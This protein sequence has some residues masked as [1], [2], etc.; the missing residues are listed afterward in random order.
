MSQCQPC[1]VKTSKDALGTHVCIK[2]PIQHITPLY[3][4]TPNC[5]PSTSEITE[6]QK[7]ASG[8]ETAIWRFGDGICLGGFCSHVCFDASPET[9]GEDIQ[10]DELVVELWLVQPPPRVHERTHTHNPAFCRTCGEFR[11]I[12]LWVVHPKRL[13]SSDTLNVDPPLKQSNEGD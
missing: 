12:S 1:T 9:W 2:C 10:F 13:P 5:P 3:C 11:W 8:N 6:R 4:A 7:K